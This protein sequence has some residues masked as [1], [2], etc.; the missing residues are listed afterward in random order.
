MPNAIS[1]IVSNSSRNADS[2]IEEGRYSIRR[3]SVD[4]EE[5]EGTIHLVYILTWMFQINLCIYLNLLAGKLLAREWLFDENDPLSKTLRS[6]AFMWLFTMIYLIVIPIV[7]YIASFHLLSDF[8]RILQAFMPLIIIVFSIIAI[9]LGISSGV[10]ES[11]P[12][13]SKCVVCTEYILIVVYCCYAFGILNIAGAISITHYHDDLE[14]A[15]ERS[16]KYLP[17]V[18]CAAL[19]I[20]VGSGAFIYGCHNFSSQ[21]YIDC[22][23]GFDNKTTIC[24]D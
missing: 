21:L 15:E 4:T 10:P 16:G 11:G 19:I 12:M 23:I 7:Q 14:Y 2:R 8:P 5:M 6:L 20:L 18:I 13:T 17:P 1:A 3:N 22:P 24:E 9:G